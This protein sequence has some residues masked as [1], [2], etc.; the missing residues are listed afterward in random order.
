MQNAVNSELMAG[1]VAVGSIA[2]HLI[3]VALHTMAEVLDNGGL[4]QPRKAVL[5]ARDL[6]LLLPNKKRVA[7]FQLDPLIKTL[8]FAHVQLYIYIYT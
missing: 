3:R 5:E 7:H 2:D 4:I 8:G 6:A 1:Q